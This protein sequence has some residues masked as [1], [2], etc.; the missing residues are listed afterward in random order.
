VVNGP[1]EIPGGEFVLQ[2]VDPQGAMF[3]LIGKRGE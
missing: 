1:M 3:S 2:G